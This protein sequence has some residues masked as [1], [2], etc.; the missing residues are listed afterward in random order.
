MENS[1]VVRIAEIQVE[2]PEIRGLRLEQLDGSPFGEW[3]S[4]AHVDVTGPTGVLRQYSLAGSPKDDSSLWIAVKREGPSGGSAA[5]HGL[6]VGDHLKISK[7]RNLLGIVPDAPR[8]ILIAGGIGL[9]P[10]MSMA[11]ELYSWGANFELHYFARSRQEMAFHDFLTERVE[12]R[13]AVTLHVGVPRAEQ[14]EVFEAIASRTP[15]AARVYTCG[16]E[17]FMDQVVA[18]FTPAVGAGHIHREAFTPKEIDT[19]TDT[20]FTVELESGE[21]YEIPA[22]RSILDVLE[23]AGHEVFRSCGEGICGSCVSGV[24]DGIP[25]HRDSCLSEKVK[26]NNEEM[27]LCVSRSRS[28]KLVIELY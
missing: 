22:D 25:D 4:G 2:T 8:H 14:P 10:L 11:F 12:Y 15:A 13:D 5:I 7:P 6:K 23:E 20:A 18:A 3:H 27:A 16:P 17:G 26:A 28:P 24:V 21:V 19:S 1:I 9:T